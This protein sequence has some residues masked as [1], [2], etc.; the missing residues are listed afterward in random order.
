M[1][2]ME[3]KFPVTFLNRKEQ[4]WKKILRYTEDQEDKSTSKSV[5][6][7]NLKS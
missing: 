7:T 2:Y 3:N 5:F 1:S 4:D 6:V